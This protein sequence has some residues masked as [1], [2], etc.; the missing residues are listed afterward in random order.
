MKSFKLLSLVCLLAGVG[1]LRAAGGDGP[2]PKKEAYRTARAVAAVEAIQRALRDLPPGA[3]REQIK[4][5]LTRIRE[6][7]VKDLQGQ[8]SL[9]KA[10][11]EM[12]CE[13]A[14]WAERMARKGYMTRAQAQA[15]RARAEAAN[16]RV[17]RLQEDLKI[18]HTED[19]PKRDRDR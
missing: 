12:V 4:K 10:D 19:L 9:A 3:D 2:K 7:I 17:Q 18:L 16:L 8:L 15:D 1:V 13:R 5:A 6:Q 14:A 11:A